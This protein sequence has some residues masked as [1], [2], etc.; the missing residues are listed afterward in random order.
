MI[1]S[2]RVYLKLLGNRSHGE[3]FEIN[4]DR[5]DY[6]QVAHYPSQYGKGSITSGISIDRLKVLPDARE[7]GHL[8]D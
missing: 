5:D 8:E 6:I 7:E 1:E 4:L 3:Q 2:C